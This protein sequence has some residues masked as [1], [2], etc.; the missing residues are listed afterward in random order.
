MK[1][2]KPLVFLL[3]AILAA[4][5]VLLP[6]YFNPIESSNNTLQTIDLPFPLMPHARIALEKDV[7]NFESRLALDET[8]RALLPPRTN[9]WTRAKASSIL[10]DDQGRYG[11]CTAHAFSYAFQLLLLL[12]PAIRFQRPSRSYW[13]ATSRMIL[14][15]SLKNDMGSTNQATVQ[16]LEQYGWI[17]EPQWPYVHE[18]MYRAP[19][20]A[21]IS[22]AQKRRMRNFATRLR[23]SNNVQSNTNQIKAALA[24]GKSVLVGVYVF[25]SFMGSSA[26]RSGVIPMPNTQRERLL[27]G[28]AIALTGYDDDQQRF[29]FRNS[30]GSRVGQNGSFTIPYS[31]AAS[32]F[33]AGDVWAL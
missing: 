3:F 26:L 27:G 7:P 12:R 4:C 23:Y 5:A 15:E 21:A 31:Y 10:V 29:S 9:L 25:S 11:S 16:A 20:N 14:R 22:A 8:E 6:Y 18:N 28:H 24:S 33:L 19:S 30:W 13:Y 2:Y 1:W 17:D 32:P